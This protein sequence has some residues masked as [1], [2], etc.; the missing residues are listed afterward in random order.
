M[1]ALLPRPKDSAW[2]AASLRRASGPP[3]AGTLSIVSDGQ[4]LDT[5]A[6]L[7][8]HDVIGKSG[9]RK[10][11][12]FASDN[13]NPGTSGGKAFDQLQNSLHFANEP[14]GNVRIP[15]P[16]PARRIAKLS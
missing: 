14:T 12:R 6:H 5:I 16:V 11:A 7:L 10:S 9:D 4:N 3:I 8:K 2:W 15:F 1:K 13:R